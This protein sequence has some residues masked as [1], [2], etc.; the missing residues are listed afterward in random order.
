MR[1]VQGLCG[2]LNAKLVQSGVKRRHRHARAV[3]GN[4]VTKRHIVQVAFGGLKGELFAVGLSRPE[5]FNGDDLAKAC[6]DSCKHPSIFAENQPS[7]AYKGL[8]AVFF[9]HLGPAFFS[10]GLEFF[11]LWSE[12]ISSAQALA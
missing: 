10:K 11:T 1:F 12:M 9:L 8:F 3:D 6:D 2:N 4:A 5:V 7:I